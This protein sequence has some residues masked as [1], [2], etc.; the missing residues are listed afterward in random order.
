MGRFFG[1]HVHIKVEGNIN[2]SKNGFM[3]IPQHGYLCTYLCIYYR[4]Q[5]LTMAHMIQNVN[6]YY[7]THP[8]IS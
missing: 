2:P 1:P 4:I 5:R 6:H 8:K 7:I 3:I